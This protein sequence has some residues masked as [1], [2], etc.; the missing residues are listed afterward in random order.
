MGI[1]VQIYQDRLDYWYPAIRFRKDDSTISAIRQKEQGDWKNLSAEDKKT[2][3]FSRTF[4]FFIVLVNYV[5]NHFLRV[6]ICVSFY[7]FSVPLCLP[8][9]SLRVRSSYWILEGCRRNRLLGPFH[10][11][12]V[13]HSLE[14]DWYVQLLSLLVIISLCS[15]YP[16]LPPTFQD[17]YKQAQVE[18]MLVL[19]K[20][21]QIFN[22]KFNCI[23]VRVNS[24]DLLNTTITITTSGS[25]CFR[26]ELVSCCWI[27]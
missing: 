16:E 15:V 5:S 13:H 17:E 3:E 23:F 6:V 27:K 22:N 9:N 24:W 26:L 11:Y 2:C 8:S 14:K 1:F 25:K 20:V 19:E 12:F 18:R 4:L 10:G 21:C 7:S